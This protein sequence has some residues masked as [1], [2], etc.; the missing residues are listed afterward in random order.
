[1]A[2]W[3][4]ALGGE[5]HSIAKQNP[6]ANKLDVFSNFQFLKILDVIVDY[7]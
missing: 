6:V 5:E 3:R 2:A 7:D 4:G 1:M